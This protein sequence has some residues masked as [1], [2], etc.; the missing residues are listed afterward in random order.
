MEING[1]KQQTCLIYNVKDPKLFNHKSSGRPRINKIGVKVSTRLTKG[2]NFSKK[3]R[4]L[5]QWSHI[6]WYKMTAFSLPEKD[7]NTHKHTRTHTHAQEL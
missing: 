4:V 3:V 7:T 6:K 5:W 2:K 1:N